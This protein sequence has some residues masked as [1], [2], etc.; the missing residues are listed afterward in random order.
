[1]VNPTIC[2]QCSVNHDPADGTCPDSRCPGP[3][4]GRKTP[5]EPAGTHTGRIAGEPP[6]PFTIRPVAM[7]F[8]S[9]YL[10]AFTPV[11]LVLLCIFVRLL[12]DGIFHSTSQMVPS[13]VPTPLSG[14]PG[15]ASAAMSQ[16]MG[17]LTTATSGIGDAAT[18]TILLIAP[19]GIFL[20]FTGIGWVLRVAEI[21]TGAILTL[22]MSG[23]AALILAGA[24]GHMAISAKYL[25]LLLQWIAFLVQ[26]FSILAAILVLFGVEKFRRSISYTITQD[27]IVIRGGNITMQEHSLPN[28]LIGRVVL[29]QDLISTV[30]NYGTIIP[31]SVTRWG[32]EVSFRGIGAAG[33]RD[34]FGLG[35]GY[36]HAR[37]EASRY[38]LDCLFGI[39]EPKTAQQILE[40]MMYRPVQRE[41]EQIAYLKTLCEMQ[42]RAHDETSF[43]MPVHGAPAI[44]GTKPAAGRD[45][46]PVV[47][48]E[49]DNKPIPRHPP[50]IVRIGDD[51]LPDIYACSVCGKK[52]LPPWYGSDGTCYCSDHVQKSGHNTGED[53]RDLPIPEYD[54]PAAGAEK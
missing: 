8:L 34:S 9:R 54:N 21:W 45:P 1:M 35:I 53:G 15:E 18:V 44:T 43:I 2:P 11:A 48:H 38:P 4:A 13:I 20:L 28:H 7:S 27:N 41:E 16:F 10:L 49:A 6:F 46:A 3:D 29:E 26:P 5:P 22:G 37:E 23:V 47:V 50:A 52:E 51:D 32:S 24:P 30:F 12:L 33:Q 40:K 25:I 36:A 39:P 42:R 31:Q 14:S 17:T 19:V